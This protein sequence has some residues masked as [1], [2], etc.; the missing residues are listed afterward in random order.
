M[1]SGQNPNS[2]VNTQDKQNDTK[3]E[4]SLHAEVSDQVAWFSV[5]LSKV[6]CDLFLIALRQELSLDVGDDPKISIE[7]CVRI[8]TWH[9]C[10]AAISTK[11]AAARSIEIA[12][13]SANPKK[14]ANPPA[15]TPTAC[16]VTVR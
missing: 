3:P 12:C 15:R 5:W 11:S 6:E 1:N 4:S 16:H 13:R 7:P 10:H 14:T 9:S 2:E 8:K